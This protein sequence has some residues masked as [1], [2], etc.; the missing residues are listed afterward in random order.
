MRDDSSLSPYLAL[1]SVFVPLSLVAIGGGPSI[2]APIQKEAVDVQKWMS[3]REFI[4]IFAVARVA[5]GPG[6]M[7]GTLIGWKVAGWGGAIVATLA[8]FVPS[9]IL[10]LAVSKVWNRYRGREWHTAMEMGL[11]P[12]G[13]GLMFAG[14][15][16]IFRMAD[17]GPLAWSLAVF[18]GAM[19]TWRPR[20]HPFA[21]LGVGAL[22]F[23]IQLYLAHSDLLR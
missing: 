3:A 8:L 18:V 10:C 11:A 17:A 13:T 22:V 2:F 20:M 14:C 15:I 23:N 7:L 6:S 21:L 4:E 9:S 5:P 12:I 1:M 16:A 19:L